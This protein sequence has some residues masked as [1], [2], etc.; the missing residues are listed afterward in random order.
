MGRGTALTKS[1]W[2]RGPDP[3]AAMRGNGVGNSINRFEHLGRGQ[4]NDFDTLHQQKR[5]TSFVMLRSIA[6]IVN[7]AVDLDA[8]F[9][10][11]AI[12]VEH[13][14]SYRMLPAEFQPIRRLTQ[15]LPK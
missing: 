13:I 14:A 9:G 5:I 7:D 12:K 10:R 11:R 4:A 3:A 6:H 2:W 15:N 8:E 1:A